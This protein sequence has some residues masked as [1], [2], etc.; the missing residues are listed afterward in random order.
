MEPP[1]SPASE[2]NAQPILAAIG[3]LFSRVTDVLEIGSGTGQHAVTFA[4]ALPHLTWH[5]SDLAENHGGIEAWLQARPASNVRRPLL[6]DV[7]NRPWPSVRAG[8]VFSANTAHIMS[9]LQVCAMFGGVAGLLPR[10]GLF[11]LYGPFNVGGRFTSASNAAFDAGLR[12]RW[13]H[14]GIRDR[15]D[16]VIVA[17]HGGLSLL[18]DQEMPA[19]NRLLVFQ[20]LDQDQHEGV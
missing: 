2:R 4:P 3:P 7:S 20:R 19:N 18:T 10:G 15:E 8:A 9:W 14:M 6:L 17:H 5:T 13:P 12:A 16:L 11:C 1:S